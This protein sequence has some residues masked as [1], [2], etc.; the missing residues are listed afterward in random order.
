M[1][2]RFTGSAEGVYSCHPR[3]MITRKPLHVDDSDLI[4]GPLGHLER[5]L[6]VPTS[7]SYSLIRLRL[8]EISRH[9][10]DRNPLVTAPHGSPSINDIW[11]I[12]TELQ[13]LLNDFQPYFTMSKEQLISTYGLTDA[14]ANDFV[15][16]GNMLHFLIYA[17]R[18]VLLASYRLYIG[19]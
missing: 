17:Q 12:D 5:P 4:D 8:A 15:H 6:S 16:H 3:H 11:D 9:R 18:Y 13:M 1:A 14:R 19:F 10:V 2:A 7:M